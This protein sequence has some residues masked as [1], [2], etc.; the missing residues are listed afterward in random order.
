M[1]NDKEA[2]R[3]FGELND[4]LFALRAP[5]GCKWDR[6]QTHETL[7]KN[8]KE[9][10]QEV[11]DAIQNKDDENLCEELGDLLLQVIFHAAIAEE[12]KRFSIRE[13]LDGVN[14]K[15]I[16]RHP[17]VFGGAKAATPEEALALWKSVKAQEKALKA[18]KKE[19]KNV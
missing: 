10:S 19:K 7:I 5:N 11:I 3:L 9:E 6:A 18:A 15:L 8:L 1:K 4:T 16:R 12:Q 14:K 13:V 2:Q 17:H